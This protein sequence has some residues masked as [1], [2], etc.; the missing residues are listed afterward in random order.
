MKKLSKL[1]AIALA[2]AIIT[3]INIDIRSDSNR[4]FEFGFNE[5]AEAMV[6]MDYRLKLVRFPSGNSYWRCEPEWG[7]QCDTAD[8][9]VL[10]S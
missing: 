2:L 9:T 3:L 1:G 6:Y 8:Q 7:Y 10:P 5:S 4:A